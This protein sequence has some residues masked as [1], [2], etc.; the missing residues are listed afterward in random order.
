MLSKKGAEALKGRPT[1]NTTKVKEMTYQVG[2]NSPETPAGTSW[3]PPAE[4]AENGSGMDLVFAGRGGPQEH[5]QAQDLVDKLQA[6]VKAY[7]EA[8]REAVSM[9]SIQSHRVHG[10]AEA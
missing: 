3:I 2:S 5:P 9:G 4:A 7:K 6:K 8:G 10:L 1:R